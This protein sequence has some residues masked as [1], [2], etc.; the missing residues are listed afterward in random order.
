MASF[1]LVLLHKKIIEEFLYLSRKLLSILSVK[2]LTEGPEFHFPLYNHLS[3][4][5]WEVGLHSLGDFLPSKQL[6]VFQSLEK[7]PQVCSSFLS[8]CDVFV[9]NLK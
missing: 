8:Q 7:S 5:L 4:I 3:T 6:F 1:R 2:L 9:E